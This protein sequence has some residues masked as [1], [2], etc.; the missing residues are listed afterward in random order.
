[1]K[2]LVSYLSCGNYYPFSNKHAGEFVVTRFLD[3]NSKIIPFF[4]NYQIKGEKS[5]DFA[6]FC[7][8][9]HLINNKDH[10]TPE[11][12]EHIRKIKAGMNR[13]RIS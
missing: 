3:I 8:L 11:G 7:K 2:S 4:K 6:D 5:K 12:L 10:L 9:A 13:G 1:M